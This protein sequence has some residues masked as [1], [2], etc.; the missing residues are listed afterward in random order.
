MSVSYLAEKWM[1]DAVLL[2]LRN[3]KLEM[4]VETL[5]KLFVWAKLYWPTDF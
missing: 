3:R 5:P 4:L 1:R 2:V